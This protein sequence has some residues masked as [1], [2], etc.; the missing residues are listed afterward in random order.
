MRPKLTTLALLLGLFLGLGP[1]LLIE[2]PSKHWYWC[3]LLGVVLVAIDGYNSQAKMLG[4]G[5]PGED[6]L[7]MWLRWL[8]ERIKNDKHAANTDEGGI[9][10]RSFETQNGRRAGGFF[11]D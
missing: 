8:R 9:R 7:K 3:S 6:L 4:L 11:A 2:N 10:S 1:W 5:E